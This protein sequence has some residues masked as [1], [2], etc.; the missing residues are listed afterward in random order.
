M[1]TFIYFNTKEIV[2]SGYVLF[3]LVV[4]LVAMS[5]FYLLKKKGKSFSIR[6]FWALFIG[7]IYGLYLHLIDNV[8]GGNN[9]IISDTVVWTNVIGYGY[10]RLLKMIVFPLVF[11][12]ILHTIISMAA[13]ESL[14]KYASL[15]IGLLLATTAI[16]SLVGI[17][18]VYIFDLDLSQIVAGEAEEARGNTIESRSQGLD[19]VAGVLSYLVKIIPSNPFYDLTGQGKSSVLSVVV[20]SAILGVSALGMRKY[21]ESSFLAFQKGVTVVKDIVM[22]LVTFII[23][24][25]P[26]GIFALVLKFVATSNWDNIYSMGIFVVASYFGMLVIFGL[27]LLFISLSGLSPWTYLK[28]SLPV[29]IYAFSSRTSLGTLPLN[30]KTQIEKLGVKDSVANLSASFGASIGQNACAGLYPAMLAVMIAPSVGIDPF[31][32]GF[33]V[34]LLLIITISSLGIAGVGGGATFAAILVLSAMDLPIALAGLLISIEALI[35]MGR[36]ATNVSGAM[37]TGVLSAKLT[38]NLDKTI[39]DKKES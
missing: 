11:I 39:Y 1:P 16:A 13:N 7:I 28:K 29:F 18:S 32:I 30:I 17:A 15:V 36:T 5:S 26:Y 21:N 19:S 25:T 38:N 12:C 10:V 8:A 3:N 31:S 6:V 20:F 37:T 2:M 4:A 24:L 22:G 9:A 27:H 33:L 23:K 34:Q 35:D 14:G